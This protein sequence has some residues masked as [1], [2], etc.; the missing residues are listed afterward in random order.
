VALEG[1]CGVGWMHALDVGAIDFERPLDLVKR[2]RRFRRRDARTDRIGRGSAVDASRWTSVQQFPAVDW[3]QPVLSRAPV[4]M[5]FLPVR[6]RLALCA[7]VGVMNDSLA[8]SELR[9]LEDAAAK[10]T[11]PHAVGRHDAIA[12]QLWAPLEPM[13][14]RVRSSAGSFDLRSSGGSFARGLPWQRC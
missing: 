6:S 8:G 12:S 3:S 2:N 9:P 4:S 14:V 13:A 10:R 5:D 11:Q 7:H 1:Q